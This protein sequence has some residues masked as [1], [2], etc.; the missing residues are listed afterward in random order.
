MTQTNLPGMNLVTHPHLL[1]IAATI[2]QVK[3]IPGA[4]HDNRIAAM[5]RHIGLR[6]RDETPW[7]AAYV[8]WVLELCGIA[9]T[10]SGMAR[11][12][13]SWGVSAENEVDPEPGSVVV[14]WRKSKDSASGHVGFFLRLEGGYVWLLG[15]NQWNKVCARRYPVGRIL[16][17]R[18][19]GAESS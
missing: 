2:L 6:G 9:G 10:N 15:G 5:L 1:G 16:D 4:K 7:C 3:E 8:N 11:S 19:M 18:C 17:V 14:L 12:F 13:L